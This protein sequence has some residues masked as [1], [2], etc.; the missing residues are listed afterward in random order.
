MSIYRDRRTGRWISEFDHYIDGVRHRRRKLLPQGWSRTQAE[1]FDRKEG[2]ALSAIAE[3]IARPR[4]T[5]D[6]A[7]TRFKR[8]R[9][10]GL[11]HGDGQVRHMHGNCSASSCYAPGELLRVAL[12]R[13]A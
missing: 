8:E 9:A 13:A 7:V 3:G 2:A 12:P 6:E 4:H 11:K 5:I 10:P 1:A